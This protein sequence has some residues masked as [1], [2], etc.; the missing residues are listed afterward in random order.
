MNM[1][2]CLLAGIFVLSNTISMVPAVASDTAILAINGR[3]S[4]PTCRIEVNDNQVQQHCGNATQR[5]SLS[6]S[7]LSSGRGVVTQLISL[8]DDASR[9]II[10]NRYE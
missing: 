3:V 10:L 1:K 7:P 8:P 2:T 5:I 6:A 4:A 9:Y